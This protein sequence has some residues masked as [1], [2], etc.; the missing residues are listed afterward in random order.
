MEVFKL[1]TINKE[2]LSENEFYVT[3]IKY[4]FF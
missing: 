3:N 4:I 1:Q 2:T